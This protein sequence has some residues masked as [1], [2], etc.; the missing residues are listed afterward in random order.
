MILC[1]HTLKVSIIM[2]KKKITIILSKTKECAK[3]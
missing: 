3:K 2:F 1:I